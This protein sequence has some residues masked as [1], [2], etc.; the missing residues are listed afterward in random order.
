MRIVFISFDWPEY[1]LRLTNALAKEAQV[2][3]IAPRPWGNHLQWL[4]QDVVF[5]PINKPRFRQPLRQLKMV[6]KVLRIVKAFKPDVIHIQHGH[7]W[8]NLALPL[9]RRYPLVFTIHDPRFHPGDKESQ[10]MPQRIIDF[11]F[12]QAKQVIVHTTQTA[13][14]V[15]DELKINREIVHIVPHIQ[16]GDDTA[17]QEVQE[18]KYMVLFFGRIWEYKGLEYLIKAEPFI[19]AQVPEAKFVIAGRGED[20]T[21]Y[22]NMMVH[23]EKFVVYNEYISDDK[24]AE[25][26]RQ[27]SMIV[28]PYIEASQSGVIPVAYTFE[29]PVIATD[30]GGLPEQVEN[31]RTGFLIPPRDEKALAEKIVCLLQD[32]AL[33]HQ[34]GANGKQKLDTE[35][36]ADAVAKK[37]LPVYARAIE[38]LN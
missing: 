8:L 38:G 23:P 25:L 4:D 35:W 11:G 3:L 36:S 26:F 5:R 15:I 37:T 18:D 19:T 24:R 2:C 27:A 31:G 30:V 1:C 22:Q 32:E 33:R 13:Q 21:P 14:I 17:Q 9:L 6:M 28:L 16:L 34:F 12:R 7:P 10:R 20:F 29:K